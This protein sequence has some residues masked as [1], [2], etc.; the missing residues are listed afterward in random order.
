MSQDETKFKEKVMADLQL[1][2]PIY[3]LKTQERSRKGVPD[4]LIGLRGKFVACELK[5]DGEEPDPLQ[6]VTLDRIQRAGNVAFST[7][8][9]QWPLHF[10]MLKRL[11][12]S[13]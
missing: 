9:A 2:K 13:K 4:L 5:I 7:T 3:V 6:Q 8:P 10:H 11:A 1:L 12:A